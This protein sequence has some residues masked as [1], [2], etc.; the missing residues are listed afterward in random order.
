MRVPQTLAQPQF[1]LRRAPP[2]ALAPLRRAA[3]GAAQRH[4][5][6]PRSGR[7]GCRA[8]ALGEGD[9]GRQPTARFF[10]ENYVTSTWPPAPYK[11]SGAARAS[12]EYGG[13]GG[14]RPWGLVGAGQ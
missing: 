14:R 11:T 12:V 7:A 2:F 3:L 13:G 8:A 1:F 5:W 4:H 9:R 6:V 10:L